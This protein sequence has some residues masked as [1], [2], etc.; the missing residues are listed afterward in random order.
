MSLVLELDP[1]KYITMA[2]L[3]VYLEGSHLDEMTEVHW[4]LQMKMIIRL[5]LGLMKELC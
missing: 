1:M 2:S 4:D 5:D 3:M